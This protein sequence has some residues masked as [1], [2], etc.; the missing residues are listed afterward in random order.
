MYFLQLIKVDHRVYLS[1]KAAFLVDIGHTD[2]D[3]MLSW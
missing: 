3:V 1:A 2:G